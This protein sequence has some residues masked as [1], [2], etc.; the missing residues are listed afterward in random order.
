M[1]FLQA[2]IFSAYAL[3]F[4][5]QAYKPLLPISPVISIDFSNITFIICPLDSIYPYGNY[6]ITAIFNFTIHCT[7]P[8]S[9]K[10][11]H[12]HKMIITESTHP[13]MAE[14]TPAENSTLPDLGYDLQECKAYARMFSSLDTS[15]D[16]L[17]GFVLCIAIFIINW[18]LLRDPDRKKRKNK[19]PPTSQARSS[20]DRN[21]T[22]SAHE[23][24]PPPP[25]YGA[26]PASVDLPITAPVSRRIYMQTLSFRALLALGIPLLSI[27]A[28]L[29]AMLWFC[30]QAL[31]FCYTWDSL[32]FFTIFQRLIFSLIYI[33]TAVCLV[34]W[35]CTVN[36]QYKKEKM[37]LPR[38]EMH[39]KWAGQVWE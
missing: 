28:A 32:F 13:L 31:E 1:F 18:I 10:T 30:S 38:Q 16:F 14:P 7:Q 34:S 36:S 15:E 17:I 29:S 9:L 4:F 11:W 22:P 2:Y 20:A 5:S 27:N 21:R 33:M 6:T 26:E 12:T 35:I 8:E 25:P 39:S 37:G 23:K 24:Q 3:G 19:S